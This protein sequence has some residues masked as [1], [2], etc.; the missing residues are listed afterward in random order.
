V[1]IVERVGICAL[2]D[3]QSGDSDVIVRRSEQERSALSLVARLEVCARG[4]RS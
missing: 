1:S 2:F 4:D 3:E